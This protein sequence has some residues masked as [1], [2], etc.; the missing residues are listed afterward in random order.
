MSKR[1]QS[2]EP[3]IRIMRATAG[4]RARQA[5]A[6]HLAKESRATAATTERITKGES[7]ETRADAETF[8]KPYTVSE[9]A[10]MLRL[11]PRTVSKRCGAGTIPAYKEGKLWRIPRQIFDAWHEA[12]LKSVRKTIRVAVRPKR[13]PLPISA[14]N[15]RPHNILAMTPSEFRAWC[16]VHYGE[17]GK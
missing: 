15:R 11:S 6:R 13:S 7:A 16:A 14:T 2:T 3:D 5:A 12:R 1:I 17:K 9:I 10:E 8:Q 4:A